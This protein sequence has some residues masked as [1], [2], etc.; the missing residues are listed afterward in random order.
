M[1]QAGYQP[2]S[3]APWNQIR[4]FLQWLCFPLSEQLP[5]DLQELSL[6]VSGTW[7][8][9]GTPR[10][11]SN[12]FTCV[13]SSVSADTIKGFTDLIN[14]L[15]CWCSWEKKKIKQIKPS[16]WRHR[17]AHSQPSVKAGDGSCHGD[18]AGLT[19]NSIE[20]DRN[21]SRDYVIVILI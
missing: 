15:I 16:A 8:S 6:W 21:T 10:T 13:F 12:L 18:D 20:L 5:G 4:S 7:G 19:G 14:E 2:L 11:F 1:L 9:S 3:S 17:P